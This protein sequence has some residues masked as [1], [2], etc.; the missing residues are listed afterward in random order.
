MATS[1]TPKPKKPR[2][3][4]IGRVIKAVDNRE[5]DFYD[6]MTPEQIKEFSPYVLMRYIS[7]SRSRDRD[8]NEWYIYRVIKN[9]YL[10]TLKSNKENYTLD[11]D[12]PI[13]E[14]DIEPM[15]DVEIMNSIFETSP[16]YRKIIIESIAEDGIMNFCRQ[17]KISYPMVKRNQEFLKTEI[18]QRKKNLGLM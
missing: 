17:S 14:F 12:V 3:L 11:F 2:A 4:D 1:K 9:M 13:S 16:T 7:N 6:N 15:D 10:N 5:Y 8:I 18:C